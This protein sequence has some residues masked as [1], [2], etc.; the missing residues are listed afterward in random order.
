MVTAPIVE[1][2][3]D[4]AAERRQARE[5]RRRMYEIIESGG[6]VDGH[7][8]AEIPGSDGRRG[9]LVYKDRAPRPELEDWNVRQARAG[10][11]STIG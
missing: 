11:I 5:N 7:F 9:I 4:M 1:D 10:T 8:V 2:D 6:V 3:E